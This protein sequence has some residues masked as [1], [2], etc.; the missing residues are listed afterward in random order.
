MRWLQVSVIYGVRRYGMGLAQDNKSWDS[1][2]DA[3]TPISRNKSHDIRLVGF[4]WNFFLKKL[5]FPVMIFNI[6]IM[7]FWSRPLYH[8][9]CQ[10][11]MAGSTGVYY[12]SLQ[13][14]PIHRWMDKDGRLTHSVPKQMQISHIKEPIHL[15]FNQIN[16][17]NINIYNNN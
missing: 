17:K 6:K 16:T 3:H 1:L 13:G 14:Y 5:L 7:I 2:L 11:C 12:M 8:H 15:K 9:S 10:G 4:C